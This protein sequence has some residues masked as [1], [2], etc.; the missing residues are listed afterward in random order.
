MSDRNHA[1]FT[2]VVPSTGIRVPSVSSAQ[3]ALERHQQARP[4]HLK[5]LHPL[6]PK[7]M[8]DAF[9]AWLDRKEILQA[10]LDMAKIAAAAKPLVI[11]REQPL[12]FRG[13]SHEDRVAYGRKG[14]RP[15]HA[16]P[17]PRALKRR[18]E[19]ERKQIH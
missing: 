3:A 12:Q 6:A 5:A 13:I 10:A 18:A 8:R 11:H 15:R 17:S 2:G 1:L 19:R 14:G 4:D 16:N 9:T 7:A